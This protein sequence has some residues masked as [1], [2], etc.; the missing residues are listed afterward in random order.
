MGQ[1]FG[2]VE[3]HR[4]KMRREEKDKEIELHREVER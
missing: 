1:G 4:E 2:S 3:I